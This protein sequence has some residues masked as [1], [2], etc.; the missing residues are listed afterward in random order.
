MAPFDKEFFFIINLAVG[1]MNFFPDQARNPD[2]KPWRNNSPHPKQDFWSGRNKWLKTWHMNT[3][4]SH[5]QV[6]YVRV[7]AL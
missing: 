7:W 6:D 4:D 3:D 5:L 2:G 1:G